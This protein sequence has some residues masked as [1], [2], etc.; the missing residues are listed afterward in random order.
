MA[1]KLT[2]RQANEL[3]KSIIAY[4]ASNN[5]PNSTLAMRNEL[6]LDESTFDAP[7]AQQYETL[8]AK[9]WTSVMR[10]QKK[11]M[12]LE[13]QNAALHSDLQNLLTPEQP[14]NALAFHPI[15]SSIATGSDDATIKIWDHDFGELEHTLRGHTRAVHGVDF[16]TTLLASCSSDLTIKLWDPANNYRN[17]RTLT[18]HD[19][20]VSAVRFLPQ[21]TTNNLLASAGRD[22]VLKIWDVVAGYCI[23]TIAG[24]TGWIHSLAA[25]PDGRAEHKLTIAGH[26]HYLTCCAF[27]PATAHTFLAALAGGM[28]KKAPPSDSA[29]FMATGARDMTIRLWDRE[30]RCIAVLEGHENWV[31]GLVFHPGG[32]FLVSVADDK[33][34][35]CWD[36]GKEGRCVKVVGGVHERFVSCVGWAMGSAPVAGEGGEMLGRRVVAT[37]GVD[38]TLRIFAG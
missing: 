15:Y 11:I 33:T 1:N 13:A 18:G 26:E 35:R 23:L 6:A 30:G 4:L 17:T 20:S 34:I 29:A 37:G 9:K 32:R 24:H 3:H 36:L 19:H 27:A 25:S 38:C 14:I 12:D 2:T 22:T 5:L 8:L 16:S 28:K 31:T 10:L 7:A 21:T